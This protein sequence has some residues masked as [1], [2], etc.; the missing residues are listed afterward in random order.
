MRLCL[1]KNPP[2]PTIVFSNRRELVTTVPTVSDAKR[3]FY[4]SFTRPINPLYRRVLEEMLVEMHLLS[5]NS[6]FVYDPIYALG[7]VTTYDTFMQGYQPT[8]DVLSMFNALCQALRVDPEQYRRD[9]EQVIALANQGSGGQLLQWLS[10][11][12]GLAEAPTPLRE[13]LQAIASR[14]SFKYSRLF[15][16]GLF[17]VLESAEPELVKDREKLQA[18]V[19]QISSHLH[20]PGERLLKDLDLYR[21]NLEKMAQAREV[22]EEAILADRRK[23]EQREQDKSAQPSLSAEESSSQVPD[24]PPA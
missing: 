2:R 23:R 11:P 18:T 12:E 6:T 22:M 5:V 17:T 1:A 4:R 9:E 20:L 10:T 21:S 13:M 8:A 3:A 15:A 24:S 16:I 7:V 14:D 19:E